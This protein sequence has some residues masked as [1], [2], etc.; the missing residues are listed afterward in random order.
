[1]IKDDQI[2]MP[3]A[4]HLQSALASRESLSSTIQRLDAWMREVLSPGDVAALRRMPPGRPGGAA[5]WRLVAARL[6]P[7]GHLPIGDG[8]ARDRA[9]MHWGAILSGMAHT[10]GLHRRGMRLGQALAEAGV[11]E[12]RLLRLLRANDAALWDIVRVTVHQLASQGVPLDWSEMAD[13]I[14]SDG[15]SREETARRSV[16]RAYY[17]HVYASSTHLA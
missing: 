1:M 6:E 5:F 17:R 8:Q 13:L 16:A 11:S 15:T 4:S 3:H 10:K 14:L 2:P 9:E 12:M 7:D